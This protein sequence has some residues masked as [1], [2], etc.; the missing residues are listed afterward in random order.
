MPTLPVELGRLTACSK[1]P[2][3]FSDATVNFMEVPQEQPY[4][5][6]S[7][8]ELAKNYSPEHF[9]VAV[10]ECRDVIAKVVVEIPVKK[11]A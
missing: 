2:N 11:Q 10:G 8:I 5:V 4:H 1:P 7:V 3:S 6:F 9:R